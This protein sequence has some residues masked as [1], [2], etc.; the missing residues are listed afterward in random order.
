MLEEQKKIEEIQKKNNQ[1]KIDLQ[2]KTSK[3]IQKNEETYN[4][5]INQTNQNRYNFEKKYN[6]NKME[7][8]KNNDEHEQIQFNFRIIQENHKKN[9]YEINSQ[10]LYHQREMERKK[11]D[12]I[13][14]YE[15]INEKR[16]KREEVLKQLKNEAINKFKYEK[17]AKKNTFFEGLEIKEKIKI[18]TYSINVDIV[19]NIIQK[20][21]YKINIKNTV[22]S[23]IK[24]KGNEL[25]ENAVKQ[26]IK[27]FNILVIGETGIGKST[28]INSILYLNPKNGGAEE[29]KGESIT[30]GPP[31]PYISN[32]IPYLRLFDTEGFTYEN[33]NIEQF[34]N[35]I[36]DFIKNQINKGNPEDSIHA[37]WYC[38]TGSRFEKNE[39]DFILLFQ[40]SYPDNKIPIILVYTKAYKSTQVR[41]FK[42]GCSDFLEENNIEFIDV[43]AKK[44]SNCVPKNMR[45]LFE[46]TLNKISVAFYSSTFHLIKQ[47]IKNKIN[48]YFEG[49]HFAIKNK[50]INLK[51]NINNFNYKNKILENLKSI[52]QNYQSINQDYGNFFNNIT[53]ELSAFINHEVL[54]NLNY[55]SDYYCPRLYNIYVSIQSDINKEYKI[56]LG[57]DVIKAPYDLKII[58]K[59][60][61][62]EHIRPYVTNKVIQELF[63]L[64]L[65]EYSYSLQL[66][67]INSFEEIFKSLSNSI[68]EKISGEIL[69]ISQNIYNEIIYRFN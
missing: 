33:F 64:I 36:S 27:Y 67:F 32:K 63:F 13:S 1:M 58:C 4:N 24:S 59:K 69:N 9:L 56:S 66:S 46:I 23:L 41:K 6:Y 16:R 54:K 8:K 30:K 7:I 5:F 28:L 21:N 19:P 65:I 47:G 3:I 53:E 61:I 40:K 17:K 37:I 38:V 14:F 39:K 31:K 68:N 25:I 34:Y 18:N 22:E 35:S 29:G 2:K 48:T 49:I 15:S 20:L 10:R 45:N 43:V 52:L 62:L 55:I 50:L 42:Q 44:Y 26:K 12:L 51:N 11:K 57:T 60:E